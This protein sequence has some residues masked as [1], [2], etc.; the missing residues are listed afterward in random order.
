MGEFDVWK[1]KLHNPN[2]AEYAKLCGAKGIR[3]EKAE[4]LEAALIEARDYE[5]PALVEVMADAALF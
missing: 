4:D 3:V 2:F 1:T 5:G